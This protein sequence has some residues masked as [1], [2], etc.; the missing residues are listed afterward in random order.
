MMNI[1]VVDRISRP[2]FY[3][4]HVKKGKPV[5]IK[6][7][8]KDWQALNWSKAYFKE[9]GTTMKVPVKT[10][11]ISS[12]K[13]ETFLL[14]E[15]ISRIEAY[16]QRLHE[17]KNAPAPGYLHDYPFFYVHNQFAA[18][19]EPF[20]KELFPAWYHKNFQNYIQFFVG[21]TGSCTPLHFD[22]LCTHNLFFQVVGKKKF[23]LIPQT[24]K[25][26]CGMKSWRWATFNPLE[27]DYAAFPA[28]KDVSV[29]EV[30]VDAGDILY[31]PSGML[32]QVHGLSFSVS[33][34]ID[35]HTPRSVV[36][37]M[38]GIFKGAPKQNLYY[39]WLIFLGVVCKVPPR[40]IFNYYKSYLNYVS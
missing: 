18:D 1:H 25:E 16:E 27:P 14:S 17:N 24:H 5:L 2:A 28:A 23:F 15:Y 4:E 11:D 22:T 13:K 7:M 34:N 36:K 21:A 31:I 8:M 12:G 30:T 33:F 37:G 10:G 32:H 29:Y 26:A 19:I 9:V 3:A 6:G 20:P 38:S 35:W 40:N 39:N